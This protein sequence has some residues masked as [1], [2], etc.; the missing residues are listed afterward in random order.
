MSSEFGLEILRVL[1]MGIRGVYYYGV[2]AESELSATSYLQFLRIL[3]NCWR[4]NRKGAVWLLDNDA[5]L[6][7]HA[8]I[9]F[10]D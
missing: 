10:W 9:T 3:I 5:R 8:S 7:R 4:G 1:A 2:A 6:N